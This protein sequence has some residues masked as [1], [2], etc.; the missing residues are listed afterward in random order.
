[1]L[2]PLFVMR[3]GTMIQN[4]VSLSLSVVYIY[5]YVYVYKYIYIYMRN[6]PEERSIPLFFLF[7]HSKDPG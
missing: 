2:S 5:L 3:S 4:R 7:F 6:T 1:M